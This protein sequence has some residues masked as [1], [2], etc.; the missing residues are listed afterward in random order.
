MSTVA[1]LCALP[2]IL[3]YA[4]NRP[5]LESDGELINQLGGALRKMSGS[6]ST[7]RAASRWD[8]F[9]YQWA[10]FW[11]SE[12]V[13]LDLCN[14]FSIRLESSHAQVHRKSAVSAA[15]LC[16]PVCICQT[17]CTR[18]A[19]VAEVYMTSWA[20]PSLIFIG[21][22]RTN[23]AASWGTQVRSKAFFWCI[24]SDRI[25]K[26]IKPANGYN[27][28]FSTILGLPVGSFNTQ[29][30][31]KVISGWYTSNLVIQITGKSRIESL[32]LTFVT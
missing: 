6:S 26:R 18:P 11:L 31:A 28:T 19:C 20:N 14:D 25:T 15:I 30:A 22:E 4:L 10:G 5:H 7:A 3:S 1:S 27:H 21:K 29:L 32:F 23:M 16:L 17:S 2:L 9:S 8:E 12:R 24:N 13:E